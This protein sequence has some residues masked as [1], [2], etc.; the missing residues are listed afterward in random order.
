MVKKRA[1]K[2]LKYKDLKIDT[3]HM[4]NV[5]TKAI[6]MIIEATVTISE[7]L[8]QNLNNISKRHDNKRLQTTATLGT[9]QVRV[10]RK[11]RT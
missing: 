3:Q 9:A 8:R 6:T 7:S 4:W 11:V 10:L 5:K 2:T 1:E